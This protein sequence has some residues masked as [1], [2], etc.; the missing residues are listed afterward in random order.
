MIVFSV[1]IVSFSVTKEVVAMGTGTKCIGQDKMRKTGKYGV[2]FKNRLPM[3][4]S[5]LP[6]S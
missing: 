4:P 5:F 6:V 2:K 3:L 1:I